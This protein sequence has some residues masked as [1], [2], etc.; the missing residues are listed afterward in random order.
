MSTTAMEGQVRQLHRRD[1]PAF[2]NRMI[3]HNVWQSFHRQVPDS[4]DPRIRWRLKYILLVYVAIGWSCQRCLTERFEEGRELLVKLFPDRRRPGRSYVGLAKAGR[5]IGAAA[6]QA[7]WA[8]LRQTLPRRLGKAWMWHGW[9]VFAVDGSRE[10]AP[11][12]RAN[13]KVLKIAGKDKTHPQ[14]WMTWLVHL[15]TLMLWNWRQ[16]PGNSSERAHMRKM[17]SSLPTGALVVGDVGFGGFDFLGTLLRSG[18]SVLVRC[19]SNTTL[20][21]EGAIQRTVTEGDRQFVYLWPRDRHR[22]R[23][24][25]LRMIVLKRRGKRVFL[26]TNV[27]ESERLSKAMAS[28]FYNARWGLEVNYRGFK[29]TMGRVNVLAKAPGPGAIELAGAIV[30]MGLLRL[31]A[32]MVL[33]ARME[34]MSVAAVLRVIRRAVEAVRH[35]ERTVWLWAQLL[36]ALRDTYHRRKSKRARNWPHK[37]TESPPNP[38][39]FRNPTTYERSRIHV[40]FP[41]PTP[42][43]G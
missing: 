30:A 26:L 14:W 13:E 35:G 4:G 11:H 34:Q 42:K 25:K 18:V 33:G 6:F 24:L 39:K 32:A 22:R 36:A 31:H 7:F 28:D 27:L 20:L 21:V 37:K 15:P 5:R 29:R 9:C 3:P 38:P 10:E 1:W 41:M 17:L 23:P 19:A 2:L 12:T 40:L 8:C 43:V 16:G